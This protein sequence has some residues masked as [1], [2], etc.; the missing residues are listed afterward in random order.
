M[1]PAGE[2]EGGAAQ[3]G[4]AS[5]CLKPENCDM[6][7]AALYS[8]CLRHA[9]LNR[10]RRSFERQWRAA[11]RCKAGGETF[12][13]WLFERLACRDDAATAGCG[14]QPAAP[15]GTWQCGNMGFAGSCCRGLPQS[16]HCACVSAKRMF[17]HCAGNLRRRQRGYSARTLWCLAAAASSPTRCASSYARAGPRPRSTCATRQTYVQPPHA[18]WRWRAA[19]SRRVDA[20]RC[21]RDAKRLLQRAQASPS[22]M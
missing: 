15:G 22:C 7:H 17:A 10:L 11:L 1:G 5:T 19:R 8:E 21:V 2:D 4:G 6:S 18:Q 16:M 14:S 13:S 12:N 3:C 20:R 9:C